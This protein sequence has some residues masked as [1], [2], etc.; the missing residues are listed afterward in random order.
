[1][2]TKEINSYENERRQ[3]AEQQQHKN[4]SQRR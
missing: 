1:M 4:K 3:Q 2:E